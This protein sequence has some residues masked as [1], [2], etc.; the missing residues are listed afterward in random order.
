MNKGDCI[1][2]PKFAYTIEN[3]PIIGLCTIRRAIGVGLPLKGTLAI[4]D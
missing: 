1:D 2:I 3:L 4:H